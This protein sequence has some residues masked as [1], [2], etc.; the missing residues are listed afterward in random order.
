MF[1]EVID[2]GRYPTSIFILSMGITYIWK[3]FDYLFC[4]KEPLEPLEP[5]S[6]IVSCQRVDYLFGLRIMQSTLI[7]LFVIICQRRLGFLC[8]A[9]KWL[10]RFLYV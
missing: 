6:Y 1:I 3:C 7:V 4:R 2:T 8:F 10:K 9:G 5:L